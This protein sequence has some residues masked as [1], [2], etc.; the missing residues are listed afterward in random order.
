LGTSAALYAD[1]AGR[2]PL[3]LSPPSTDALFL[4]RR[5]REQVEKRGP[6]DFESLGC[7]S[8]AE[9]MAADKDSSKAKEL[10]RC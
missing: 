4:C 3:E 5:S 1:A 7:G 10:F 6:G 8:S 2:D 9:R